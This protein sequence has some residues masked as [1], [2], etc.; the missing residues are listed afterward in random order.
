MFCFRYILPNVASLVALIFLLW[1]L[2][3]GSSQQILPNAEILQ[4]CGYDRDIMLYY[5]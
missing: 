2:F 1:C 4:V 3:A 5:N